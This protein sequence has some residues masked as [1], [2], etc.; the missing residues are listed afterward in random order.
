[1]EVV[2]SL[3]CAPHTSPYAGGRGNVGAASVRVRV[4][5]RLRAV[6]R[7]HEIDA[8]V[9]GDAAIVD[10]KPPT[11]AVIRPDEI[12]VAVQLVVDRKPP[13]V[14]VIRRRKRHPTVGMRPS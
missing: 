5:V 12:G 2:E 7:H 10:S 3:E 11:V 13:T 9:P 4:H 1:M 8:A 14:A 6:D